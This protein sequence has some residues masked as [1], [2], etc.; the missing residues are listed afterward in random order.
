MLFL[1]QNNMSDSFQILRQNLNQ[2]SPEAPLRTLMFTSLSEKEGHN[3]IAHG[4]SNEFAKDHLDT[5]L[6]EADYSENPKKG[7][8]P[9]LE[10]FSKTKLERGLISDFGLIDI[11]L[12]IHL[13]NKSGSLTVKTKDDS[14]NFEF[15]QGVLCAIQTDVK[16][17][18]EQP[19]FLTHWEHRVVKDIKARQKKND[20]LLNTILNIPELSLKE[21]RSLYKFELQQLFSYISL[22][23]VTDFQFVKQD[24]KSYREIRQWLNSF[25]LWD[26]P[27]EDQ[28]FICRSIQSHLMEKN[29]H[30]SKLLINQARL[31]IFL[32]SQAYEQVSKLMSIL[33]QFFDR[34]LIQAPVPAKTK[35]TA[36][37]GRLADGT[38]LVMEKNIHK[39]RKMKKFIHNL[40]D[41]NVTVLGAVYR[42]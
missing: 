22:Q 41:E 10:V 28:N 40:V 34:I 8:I 5:L 39:T 20:F 23:D 4:L 36:A 33:N 7:F 29:E 14:F 16:N 24:N 27:L 13:Q 1:K 3:Q 2:L 18:A 17:T 11:L 6:L 12:L 9:L 42:E 15:E 37:L 32:N 35:T 31:S 25:I 21:A 26:E 19:E 30:L 38:I